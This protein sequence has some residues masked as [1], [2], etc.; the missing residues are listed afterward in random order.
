MN[1]KTKN[2][3]IDACVR[4][5]RFRLEPIKKK[6]REFK[7][8]ELVGS[9]YFLPKENDCR[10]ALF[11]RLGAWLSTPAIK[12]YANEVDPPVIPA[13]SWLS[14]CNEFIFWSV[15]QGLFYTGSLLCRAYNFVYDCGTEGFYTQYLDKAIDVFTSVTPVIDFIVISHLHYDH[16]CGLYKI[17]NKSKVKK[18]YLPLLNNDIKF[19]LLVLKYYKN[20][21]QMNAVDTGSYDVLEALY[22]PNA[23]ERFR[24]DIPLNEIEIV[25][26][27][28]PID[29]N[30]MQYWEFNL[31]APSPNSKVKKFFEDNAA[32]LQ[33]MIVSES[34]DKFIQDFKKLN[35][36]SDSIA[37]ALNNTSTVLLHKPLYCVKE[38][39]DGTVSILTG[40]I[41]FSKKLAKRIEQ[42]V[43]ESEI[44]VFQI[45]HH[46]SKNN[47]GG[48]WNDGT[49]C[50][51]NTYVISFGCGNQYYHPDAEVVN[52][53]VKHKKNISNVTQFTSYR[54]KIQ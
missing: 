9:G 13:E 42:K 39:W 20:L 29:F 23:R 35:G 50:P 38:P 1:L 15:G 41:R 10:N 22:S 7:L 11:D 8:L 21:A 6:E 32:T 19:T 5:Y 47:W 54:Y 4:Q 40:D 3:A 37:R 46:G 25:L 30:F 36:Y 52:W 2:N 26:I 14:P 48:A 51:A 31:L 43:N 53:I 16:C 18:I 12:L 24:H 49:V 34:G 27:D 28:S 44:C 17:L 33:S 45:P